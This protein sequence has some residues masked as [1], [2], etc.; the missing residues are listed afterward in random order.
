MIQRDPKHEKDLT[1]GRF[2]ITEMKGPL[3]NVLRAA[4]QS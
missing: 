2:S 4:S 1:E 3:W